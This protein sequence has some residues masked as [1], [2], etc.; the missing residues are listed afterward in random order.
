M[1]ETGNQFI[2]P[3]LVT[4]PISHVLISFTNVADK[5]MDQAAV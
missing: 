3:K 2:T 4:I 5:Y 1:L